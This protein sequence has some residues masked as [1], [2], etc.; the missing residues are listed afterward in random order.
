[1]Q[2]GQVMNSTQLKCG[3]IFDD[4]IGRQGWGDRLA[5]LGE[6]P[7]T[8]GELASSVENLARALNSAG[9]GKNQSVGI[10]LPLSVNYITALLAVYQAGGTSVLMNPRGPAE[11]RE[12]VR[13]NS[14][15][16]FLI[17][18]DKGDIVSFADKQPAERVWGDMRVVGPMAH[19][20]HH[21]PEKDDCMIIYTSGSNSRPKGVVLSDHAI[22]SNVKAVCNYLALAPQDRTLVFT[23]PCYTYAMSQVLTHLW[24]GGAILPWC[25]GLINPAGLLK[26]INEYKLTGLAANPT[27][28]K[29]LEIDEF[30]TAGSFDSVRYVMSGGQPLTQPVATKLAKRFRMARIVNMYGC[31]ENSPRVSY[32]WLPAEIPE[33][34]DHYPVG[35][36]IQGTQ[37][38]I[39]AESGKQTPPGV[40]GQIALRGSS[41][42][43]CYWMEPELTSQRIVDGWFFTGDTGTVDEEGNLSL[44]G[45]ADNIINVGHEKVSPEE[46][47]SVIGSVDGV[48]EVAVAPVDDSL[49]VKVPVALVTLNKN[50]DEKAIL[51]KIREECVKKLS[52]AK[53]PRKIVV[54]E[55]VPKTPYGK[56]DRRGIKELV[57]K[58]NLASATL[59][60]NK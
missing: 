46:I 15:M 9:G 4:I 42:M 21:A 49:L 38:K 26:S 14:R 24:A 12:Y 51:K 32:Y 52:N 40:T 25:T 10:C 16:A 39:V 36:P 5:I 27:A 30:Q 58:L 2:H 3:S 50:Q 37:F 43:R 33:H 56:H 11:E 28:F 48:L 8:Y 31:T 6:R 44:V 1:M 59:N 54:V 13:Q 34:E 23:P 7:I 47:E 41:L 57:S 60:L 19:T 29:I 18:Q 20:G 53:I 22:S 55:A 45:R 17:T 35:Q